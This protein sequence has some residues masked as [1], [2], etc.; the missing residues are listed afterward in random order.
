MEEFA[1]Q[2]AFSADGNGIASQVTNIGLNLSDRLGLDVARSL[3]FLNFAMEHGHHVGTQ[4]LEF[5]LNHAMA[6]TFAPPFA[7]GAG[8]RHGPSRR[9][10]SR[11]NT[12]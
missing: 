3:H 7:G 2:A 10:D 9:S 1:R 8:F 5:A 4:T 6:S 11:L 12:S